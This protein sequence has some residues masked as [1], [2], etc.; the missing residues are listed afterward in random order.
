MHLDRTLLKLRLFKE[1]RFSVGW[2][3]RI[4][5][6]ACV[7]ELAQRHDIIL[8]EAGGRYFR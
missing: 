2:Q 8:F 7:E 5:R 4:E 6:V 3:V 1:Q